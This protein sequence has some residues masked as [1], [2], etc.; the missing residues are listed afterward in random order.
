MHVCELL[1]TT[2]CSKLAQVSEWLIMHAWNKLDRDMTIV[3]SYEIIVFSGLVFLRTICLPMP[4]L[5]YL[6]AKVQSLS[7][8]DFLEL[9]MLVKSFISPKQRAPF[10]KH[11]TF[12]TCVGRA[13]DGIQNGKLTAFWPAAYCSTTLD[14][15]LG[16]PNTLST[17]EQARVQNDIH[18]LY[19]DIPKD[20]L[21]PQYSVLVV[22]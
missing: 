1:L 13:L 19:K 6:A 4:H 10:D 7:G 21:Q 15:T 12:A 8:C 11:T 17:Q 9:T 3:D 18:D 22:G 20:Q 16:Y 14:K 2:T 5:L